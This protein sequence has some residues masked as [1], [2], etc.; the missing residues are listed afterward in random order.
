MRNPVYVKFFEEFGI[1]DV[2]L[3]GKNASLGEMYQKLSDKGVLIPNGFATT[4]SAYRYTLEET[5]AVEALHE[6]LDNLD[7]SDV[8]DLARRAKE[9]VKS[10][11]ALDC[12][13]IWPLRFL[14][15]ISASR[16]SMART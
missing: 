6:A 8:G 4:A 2:S 12:P 5:G 15:A 13:T 11:T 7:P 16:T 10:S 9:L 3:V 1:E 14:L